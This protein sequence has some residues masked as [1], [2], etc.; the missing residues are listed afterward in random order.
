MENSGK[1]RVAIVVSGQTPRPDIL[2]EILTHL[3][4]V[5]HDEFGI[6]DGASTD[7]IA[8]LVARS[9]EDSHFT[10]LRDGTNVILQEAA[11]TRRALK[12]V[13]RLDGLGYDL[14]VIAN[15][16]LGVRLRSHTPMVHGKYAV[17]TWVS[18]LIAGNSRI[19]VI[20]PLPHQ[21]SL[22]AESRYGTELQTCT[23]TVKGGHDAHLDDAAS[24][25]SEADLILMHSVGYTQEMAQKVAFESGRPVVTA[26]QIIGSTARMRLAEIAGRMPDNSTVAYTGAEVLKRLRPIGNQLTPRESEVLIHV[27]EG[28]GNKFIGRALGISHRT[29]EIHRSRA[30]AKLG[31]ASVI[32]LIR[33]AL[34]MPER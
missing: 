18:A 22:F 28:S 34:T 5:H 20:F 33:R 14:L 21:I 23:A 26:C 32:E 24:R 12:L 16:G 27:I 9:G 30:M 11:L 10:K 4:D 8:E 7:Q 6:L 25:L 2:R 13:D 1:P 19:G 17:D 15:S 3:G 29:V 31:V